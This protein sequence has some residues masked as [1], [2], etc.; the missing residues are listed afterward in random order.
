MQSVFTPGQALRIVQYGKQYYGQ[1]FSA[2]GGSAPVVVINDSPPL[3]FR[4]GATGGCGVNIIGSGAGEATIN[5]VNFIH[6][7]LRNLSNNSQTPLGQT[8]YAT[9]YAASANGPGEAD[10]TELV[11]VQQDVNGN[12]VNGTEEIVAEYAVDLGFQITAVTGS[13]NGGCCDPLISTVQSGAAAFTNFTTSV[14]ATGSQ[15]E[16]IRT[17]R[18]RLGVRSRES[19][20]AAG[21]AQ[22][23]SAGPTQGL[24]RFNIGSGAEPFARVRTFQADVSLNNQRDILW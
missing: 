1:I 11:R 5:V 13:T 2:S 16:L 9:L 10:R 23:T 24:F 22:D 18:V 3:Q 21:T 19:D 14:F 15:P 12:A 20:R 17:V 8:N 7:D 4:S 6:Y